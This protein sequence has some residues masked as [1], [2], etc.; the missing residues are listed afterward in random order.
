MEQLV[1]FPCDSVEVKS[2]KKKNTERKYK[3]SEKEQIVFLDGFEIK[4]EV[5]QLEL[6]FFNKEDKTRTYKLRTLEEVYNGDVKLDLTSEQFKRLSKIINGIAA[7]R[8][9][10]LQM[11]KEEVIGELWIKSLEVILRCDQFNPSVIAR[12]CWNKLNDVCRLGK[13]T[14]EKVVLSSE[15]MEKIE[16]EDEVDGQSLSIED[17]NTSKLYIE[18]ILELFPKNSNECLYL[19]AL[20]FQIGLDDYL[21]EKDIEYIREFEDNLMIKNNNLRQRREAKIAKL[22]GFTSE[23]AVG[24][25]TI[26]DNVRKVLIEKGYKILKEQ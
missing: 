8:N 19:K 9:G 7:K 24:Y 20:M 22:L 16:T 11:P 4:K 2:K 12:S 17:D 21:D 14:R 3:Y 23:S 1:L 25:R 10:W 18:E 26:R 6:N 13:R 5:R 15:W